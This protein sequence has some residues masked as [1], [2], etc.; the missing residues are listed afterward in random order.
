MVWRGIYHKVK[1]PLAIVAE[2][3]TTVRNRDE[4]LLQVVV[5]LV[6][7]CNL[8][9]QHDNAR[10]MNQEFINSFWPTIAF[11]PLAGCP[12]VQVVSNYTSKEQTGQEGKGPEHIPTTLN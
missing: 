3:L 7:Q 12:A 9:F 4:I 1:S 2:N 11:N 5:P 8:I 10:L 6:Q